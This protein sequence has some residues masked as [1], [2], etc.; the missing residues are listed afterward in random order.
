MQREINNW[1][2]RDLTPFGKV[3]VIKTLIVSK[4]VHILLS[5]PSPNK[6]TFN[7]INK[8]L[9]EFLWDGK[10]DKIKRN[11]AKQKLE[12]GGIAM[13]D[14]ELFDKALKMTWIRRF[15]TGNS[16]WKILTS[17]MYPNMEE[18]VNYGNSFIL[19][20]SKTIQNPFWKNVMFCF[21]EFHS[22][23]ILTSLEEL[24]SLS[25]LYNE[26]FKIGGSVIINK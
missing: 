26:N 13:I 8:M 7:K 15:L 18:I 5:L 21:Y 9:Y 25:F 24:E 6:A 10:P 2:K 12:N 16:K 4:I 17:H 11:I 22:K 23:V 19:N 1:L 20:L 3:T 14:I